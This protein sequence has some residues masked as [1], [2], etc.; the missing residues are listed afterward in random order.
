M[1]QIAT[2]D[3]GHEADLVQVILDDLNDRSPDAA[4]LYMVLAIYR[5]NKY[6]KNIIDELLNQKVI[7]PSDSPYA[8]AI[9]SVKK[10]S[11]ER[12]MCIDFRSLK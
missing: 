9:V 4:V 10:K 11:G 1:Q 12:R 6:V 2:P 3:N 7:R 5:E 8:F